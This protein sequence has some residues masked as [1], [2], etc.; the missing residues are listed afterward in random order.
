MIPDEDGRLLEA[1]RAIAAGQRVD[2][3]A[4]ESSTGISDALGALPREARLV[5]D[6]A[7]LHR[8]LPDPKVPSVQS[9]WSSADATV[10]AP[11]IQEAGTWSALQLLEH[12]GRGAF[13]DVYRAWDP[14]LDREVA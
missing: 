2:W 8:S 10:S 12:V 9:L 4:I 13:G 6:I 3:R 5:D 11:P 14:R 7:E 1:A